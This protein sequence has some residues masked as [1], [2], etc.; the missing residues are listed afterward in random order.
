MLNRAFFQSIGLVLGFRV[1]GFRVFEVRLSD[2][3]NSPLQQAFLRSL[4]E[5]SLSWPAKSVSSVE[6]ERRLGFV[7]TVCEGDELVTNQLRELLGVK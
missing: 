1:V 2:L 3:S 6:L 4:V 5:C 7:Q